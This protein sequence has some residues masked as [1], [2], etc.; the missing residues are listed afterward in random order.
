MEN[1]KPPDEPAGLPM[2]P[3][4]PA[5]PQDNPAARIAAPVAQYVAP[6]VATLNGI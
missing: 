6:E 4:S 2:M 3:V 1:M 5:T